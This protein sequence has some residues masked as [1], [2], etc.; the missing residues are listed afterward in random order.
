MFEINELNA[1]R[2]DAMALGTPDWLKT[3][4]MV[5]ISWLILRRR[6]L[7][8]FIS[9]NFQNYPDVENSQTTLLCWSNSHLYRT[10]YHSSSLIILGTVQLGFFVGW[11]NQNRGHYAR[12]S[13]TWNLPS[14]MYSTRFPYDNATMT[15]SCDSLTCLRV[16][17]RGTTTQ[18]QRL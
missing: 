18:I 10:Y 15:N 3:N 1:V 7:L 16:C 6:T 5:W 2:V 12:S 14:L 8:G 17:V 11:P 4:W 9:M 13:Q